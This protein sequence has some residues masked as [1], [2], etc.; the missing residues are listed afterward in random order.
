M[1]ATDFI[2]TLQSVTADQA[3]P[4]AYWGEIAL[5]HSHKSRHYHTLEHLEAVWQQLQPVKDKIEDW[6]VM[7]FAIGY[8]DFFYD[9]K[10]EDNERR[11]AEK[12]V[13]KMLDAGYSGERADRCFRHI[14]ATKSHAVSSDPDTNYF[15][16]ADL[17]ILGSDPDAYLLYAKGVREEYSIYP[18]FMYNSGRKRVLK[19]FLH[20][21]RI[22]K[23]DHFFELYENQARRNIKNENVL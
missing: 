10:R 18:S 21:P 5:Q 14:I 11:S 7:L 23:T 17:S 3:L 2:T 8:H 20:L 13:S 6:E 15:T 22:F 16:D 19:H 12:A 4:N 1:L 9:V